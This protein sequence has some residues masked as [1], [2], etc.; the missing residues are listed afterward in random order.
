MSVQRCPKCYRPAW[1]KHG[2]MGGHMKAYNET[3]CVKLG[4]YDCRIAA[5]GAAGA[6]AVLLEQLREEVAA[7]RAAIKNPAG[8]E[9]AGPRRRT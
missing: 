8:S 3:T 5:E 2:G 4:G 7:I 1:V 9:P 6:I